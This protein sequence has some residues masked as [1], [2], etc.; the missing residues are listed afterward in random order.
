MSLLLFVAF[1]AAAEGPFFATGVKVGEVTD[2]EAILWV[3]LTRAPE[4]VGVEGGLPEVLY[5][6]P[7]TGKLGENAKGR[8]DRIPVV[9]YPA[10]GSVH[11]LEGAA[12]GATGDVRLAYKPE[13][14]ADWTTLEWAP[15]DAAR[16]YTRQI[17]LADLKPATLYE[18][19]FQSR[20][21]GMAEPADL[22]TGSFKTAPAPDDPAKVAFV[23]TTCYEYMDMDSPGKGFKIYPV[24]QNLAPDFFVNNGDIVYYDKLAKTQALARWHWQRIYSLPNAVEFHRFVPSYFMKDDHDT[25]MNDCW[26]VM[27]TRYMGEFTFK[28]G[29]A[30]F[31]EQVPIK[32][33]TYRTFRWGKDLQVWLVEGRDYRSPNTMPDG[34]KKTIWGPEQKAWFKR[35]VDESDAA[36]RVLISPTPL[37]GPDRPN[38]NDNHANKGF[39]HEGDELR[40]FLASRKNMVVM[41]GDR[42]WQYFSIDDETGLHEYSCGAASD[43]HAGGWKKDEF[44]PEHQ[45]MQV[46]GGFLLVRVERQNGEPVMILQHRDVDGEILNE[47]VFR[48]K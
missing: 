18:Y 15:V 33:P 26:P 39:K 19:R 11:T 45:Y 7:L 44:L 8:P 41:N 30:I 34:P 28:Q 4:R 6:V 40:Q 25:W 42:H 17:Q 20:G 29:Q 27:Q 22:I 35:T 14:S 9:T 43:E 10:G 36:F 46:V 13:A 23:V 32:P 12:P 47:D 38:K 1:C 31:L 16:D 24:M 21:P 37:V 48:G 2:T 3:R 5:R